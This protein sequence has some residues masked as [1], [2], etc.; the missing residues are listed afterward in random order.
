VRAPL[1]A[2]RRRL[3]ALTLGVIVL[4]GAVAIYLNRDDLRFGRPTDVSIQ[5]RFVSP[6]GD[7]GNPLVVLVGF[8]WTEKGYCSGQFHVKANE[9]PAE[10]TVGDVISRTY[11][12]GACAGLGTDGKLAWAEMTLASPIGR[13]IVVRSS[14]GAALPVFAPSI[15]LKC[16]DAVASL[17]DPPAD[18]STVFN[19]I[20]LPTLAALQASQSGESDPSARIFAKAA[21]YV[22]SGAS[23][24]LS[25]P[26][27]LIGHMSIGWGSPPIRAANVYVSGCTATGTQKPWLVFPG[28][29][30]TDVPACIPLLVR[31]TGA[32]K[33]V[34]IGVG[35]ACPGQAA[36][37]P[38]S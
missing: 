36:P 25:V 12:R 14:D 32:E 6:I 15:L 26:D 1:E 35:A 20:A 2:K 21:L 28:G 22:V 18:V 30:W 5:P 33:S 8:T 7:G 13:R 29:F 23:F 37:P 3:V 31:T 10:V 17:A 16:Q 9:S 34:P 19:G 24:L 11:S 27:E 38:G 4:A